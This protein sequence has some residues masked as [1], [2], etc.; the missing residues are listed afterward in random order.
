[1]HCDQNRNASN[2]NPS[3]TMEPSAAKPP[4]IRENSSLF[5]GMI[6]PWVNTALR[7]AIWY[8]GESNVACSDVWPYASCGVN[9]A[10]TA[11]GCA[12]YYQ[13]Q[14]PAMISDW[15]RRFAEPWAGTSHELTFLSV[16]LPAYV[17]DQSCL[18]PSSTARSTV[19]CRCS[20]WRRRRLRDSGTRS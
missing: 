12:D 11:A 4:N 17:Q 9:C 6:N 18:P 15:R 10:M 7:G 14:F 3:C 5:N 16:G 13:C 19:A 1:M 2:L 8:Q 20:G